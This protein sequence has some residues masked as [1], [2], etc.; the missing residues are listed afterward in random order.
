MCVGRGVCDRKRKGEGRE[1]GVGGKYSDSRLRRRG[2]G[3]RK[4]DRG[5]RSVFVA[6]TSNMSSTHG[7]N[8]GRCEW[9]CAYIGMVDVDARSG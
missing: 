3:V 9:V 4:V 2:E 7:R 8:M 5:G 6:V 1:V